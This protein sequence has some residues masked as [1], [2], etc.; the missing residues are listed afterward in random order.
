[1]RLMAANED[2]WERLRRDYPPILDTAQVAE[3]L[4]LNVRTILNMAQDGRLTASRI[5]GSR[6]FLFPLEDVISVLDSNLNVASDQ[7]GTKTR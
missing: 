6:K 5:P 4:G 3:L 1:M 2:R 7:G